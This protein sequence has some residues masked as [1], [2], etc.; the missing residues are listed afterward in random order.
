MANFVCKTVGHRPP[1][2]GW[3]GDGLYGRIEHHG[4]DGTGR[5]HASVYLECSRC[6]KEY[7]AARFHPSEMMKQSFIRMSEYG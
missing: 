1:K 7:R 2:K 6:K 3:W 4:P 5:T